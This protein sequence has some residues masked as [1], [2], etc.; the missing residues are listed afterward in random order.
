MEDCILDES[1]IDKNIL[2]Y[3]KYFN[4]LYISSDENILLNNNFCVLDL[5]ND[6]NIDFNDMNNLVLRMEVIKNIKKEIVKLLDLSD[7]DY[8]NSDTKIL[9]SIDIL[10]LRSFMLLLSE[11]MVNDV[12]LWFYEYIESLEYLDKHKFDKKYKNTEEYIINSFKK[13]NDDRVKYLRKKKAEN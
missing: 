11:E 12:K 2:I 7:E 4:A 1:A 3:E 13:Y 8:E 6:I 9:C 5:H 10:S